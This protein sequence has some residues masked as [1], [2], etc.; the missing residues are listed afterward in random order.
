VRGFEI[1]AEEIV[2][3]KLSIA[4]I[5]LA[6]LLVAGCSSQ[7]MADLQKKCNDGDQ[8]ACAQ[9]RAPVGPMALPLKG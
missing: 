4:A 1:A 6:L 2:M 5:A 3:G 8:G 9:V 7:E